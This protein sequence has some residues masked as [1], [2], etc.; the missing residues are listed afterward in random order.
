VGDDLDS[1][2][3]FDAR[4]SFSQQVSVAQEVKEESEAPSGTPA[5]DAA[6]PQPVT[7]APTSSTAPA[8]SSKDVQSF[9][10]KLL[11]EAQGSQVDSEKVADKL[12]KCLTKLFHKLA[13]E[14]DFD[15]PKQR[16]ADHVHKK[17]AQ[18]LKDQA[19]QFPSQAA[20]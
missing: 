5:S 16:L 6:A 8:L 7:S 14:F 15:G 19:E 4:L 13:K 12:P 10:N 17:T 1:S 2:V 18:G 3:S 11:R 9:V 20:A